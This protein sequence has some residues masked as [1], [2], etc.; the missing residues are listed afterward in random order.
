MTYDPLSET[1]EAAADGDDDALLLLPPKPPDAVSARPTVVRM[2]LVGLAAVA[3]VPP[4]PPGEL[5]TVT[6]VVPWCK[7]A[8]DEGDRLLL[9]MLLVGVRPVGCSPPVVTITPQFLRNQ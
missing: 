4:L 2:R 9:P 6:I 8:V 5:F 7:M 1:G 3:M